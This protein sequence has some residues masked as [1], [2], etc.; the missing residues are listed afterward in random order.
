MPQRQCLDRRGRLGVRQARVHRRR[1][2]QPDVRARD[3]CERRPGDVDSD[4]SYT[5]S[6]DADFNGADAFT[7]SAN[8]G[9]DSSAPA[10]IAITI[11]GQRRSDVQ[12]RPRPDR[13]ENASTQT[14]PAGRPRSARGSPN[15]SGK[16]L[17][18]GL[19]QQHGPLRDPARRQSDR[20]ADLP[21]EVELERRRDSER[22]PPRQ[23]GNRDGGDDTSPTQTFTITVT[24]VNDPPR[25]RPEATRRSSKTRAPVGHQLGDV[26]QSR[27]IG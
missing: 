26:D 9:T 22:H 12:H 19:E 17:D 3:G 11:A 25:S 10:T 27:P 15:E 7:Y 18:F 16:T 4:G 8:D 1:R 24:G 20:H 5:Y 23:R 13:P 21:A 14:V 2:G 6:P